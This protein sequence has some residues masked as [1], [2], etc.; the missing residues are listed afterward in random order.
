MNPMQRILAYV[1][2]IPNFLWAPGLAPWV[3]LNFLK[4]NQVAR[5]E[6]L[7]YSTIDPPSSAVI[8]DSVHILLED[9]FSS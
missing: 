9:E 6:L 1:M 8:D 2:F 3:G 5:R 4:A 7:P